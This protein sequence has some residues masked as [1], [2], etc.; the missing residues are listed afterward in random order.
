MYFVKDCVAQLFFDLVMG[1]FYV[2]GKAF[3]IL[4]EIGNNGIRLVERSSG[5]YRVVR[6]GKRSVGVA[7]KDGGRA[8]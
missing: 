4:F 2:E 6:L 3:E 5:V 7:G 1:Y 8:D